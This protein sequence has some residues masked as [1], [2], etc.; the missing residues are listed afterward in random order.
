[1]KIFICGKGGCGKSSLT[2][3]VTQ[4]LNRRGFKV[5]VVDTDESN[6]G[7]YTQLG[8][9]K[10]LDFMFYF[11]GKKVLFEQI[12][13]LPDKLKYKDIPEEY[14]SSKENIKLVSMGKINNFGE[15]C[16]CPINALA[17]KF[18]E[19]I[20]LENDQYLIAD[21]D[22]GI[23]HLGRGV[24]RGC[25][26]IF[27]VLDPSQESIRLSN[28][29]AEMAKSINKDYYYILNRINDETKGIL[30]KCVNPDKVIG[31]IPDNKNVLMVNLKGD[32]LNLKLPEIEKLA[33]FI[34]EFRK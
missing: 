3:L 8:V 28:K 11:G 20:D 34:Q 2:A 32:E 23:E 12:K 9:N 7:L 5:L 17:S 15:G 26:L 18:I 21:T 19:I 14:S 6:Y 25:D 30:L 22:A 10:P 1:M 24:D 16:A 27:I 33:D 29:I 13:N 4:E 31:I